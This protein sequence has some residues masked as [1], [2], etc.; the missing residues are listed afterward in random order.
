MEKPISLIIDD[1][2][3]ELAEAVERSQL[4]AVIIEPY[5]RQ[6]Y[7]QVAEIA[8]QQTAADREK[9]REEAEK[10]DV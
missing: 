10:E 1:L 8:A 3:R 9:Y 7:Q 5:L 4:P 2:R 6:L